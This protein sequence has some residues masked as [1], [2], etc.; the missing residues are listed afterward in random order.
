MKI[1]EWFGLALFL[2]CVFVA[3]LFI[4][5]S[6]DLPSPEA[7]S[8]LFVPESTKILDRT[9]T[10]VLYDIHGEQKRTVVSYEDMADYVRW[11]TIVAEDDQFYHH[12]GLDIRGIARAVV[13]NL[14]GGGISQGGST[15]TQQFIKNAFLTSERTFPRKIKEA[16][17]AIELE[18]KYSKDEILMLYLNQVPYGNSAYGTE[19]AAQTYFDKS[20]KDI[21]IAES[22]I[23]AALPNA[24]SYYNANREDLLVRQKNIL[25]KMLSLGYITEE[26]HTE[27]INEEIEFQPIASFIQAP[28]FVIEVK[29]Y[30]EN[31]YG[32]S[33]VQQAGLRVV[34]TLDKTVQE[35]AEEAVDERANYNI[36]NFNAHNA[37]LVAIDPYTGHILAMVGS[38]DYFGKSEPEGCTSGRACLFDPQVNISTSPQQP[39]S[40]FKPFA[41]AQAFKKGYTPDT[42]VFDVLTEFNPNC[43]SSANQEK[44]DSGLNCYHPRNYDLQYFGKITLK[45][46]LAQSRN[47]PAVKVLYLAGI[48]DTIKLANEMGIESLQESSRYGL[49]LVLGGGDVTLLEETS[50]F[51]VFAARGERNP[52]TMILRVQDKNGKILEEHTKNSQQVLE[53]NIADQINHILSIND[54]R[55]RVF[56]EQN[57]LVIPG[58]SVA[59]KTGTTQDYRDA[60]TVGYTPS[61]AAGVWVGN[62]NNATMYQAPGSQ[63]AAPIWNSFMRK[64]YQKKSVESS[65]FKGRGSYF[66][67]PSINNERSFIRPMVEKTNKPVLDGVM[68]GYHNILHYISLNNPLGDNPNNPNSNPQY[69]NWEDAVRNWAILNNLDSDT[70]TDERDFTDEEIPTEI[71]GPFIVSYLSPSK[72]SFS[73][74]ETMFLDIQINSNNPLEKSFV[75]LN[76]EEILRNTYSNTGI[77]SVKITKN[78]SLQDLQKNN[79]HQI[80]VE[81]FDTLTNT[82][83]SSFIFKIE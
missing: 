80:L 56:G 42:L 44:E 79:S 5:Y 61:I 7:L 57:S 47:V 49:S 63:A 67:L 17:L 29:Q 69:K 43:S 32:P 14:K 55:S 46:A 26:E 71:V 20:A 77:Y 8:D 35:A 72:R 4:Y 59:V 33:Y 37:S 54:Y 68:T 36:R 74:E 83:K 2:G 40:S 66:S 82:G 30:L 18:L 9:E 13:T 76:G 15:L 45:E 62:N 64:V 6:K 53:K 23:L 58:L 3:F 38:R 31:K 28:H 81:V 21:T 52:A 24:P 12:M 39:G 48:N 34:T 22:A 10:V 16:I 60:W 65:E 73:E 78:I 11:A 50:A 70:E 25:N 19:A 75:Y 41:Y 27:A 1:L 51:G